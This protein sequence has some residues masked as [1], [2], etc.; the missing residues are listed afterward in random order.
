MTTLYK[1]KSYY[2]KLGVGAAPSSAP[3]ATVVDTDANTKLADA[4][5]TTALTNLV[6]YYE[7][8]YSGADNLD[9]V[10][11]FHTTD[12]T[13]DQ[14]DLV[15]YVVDKVYQGVAVASIANDAI[16]AA[17][18]KADAVTKI[19]NGL[20]LEATLTAIKGV[21]W[22]TETLAAIDVLIDAIKVKTDAFTTSSINYVSPISGS[23]ITIWRGDTL[24]VDIAN[25][26]SLASYVTLDFTI[27]RST[28][29]ADDDAIIR[30]R[31][32]ASGTGDGLLRL[33]G[34]AHST[35]TDG[36]ITITDAPTGD[37]TIMLKAGVTDDLVPG[38]YVY[39]VQLIGSAEVSTL[40]TGTLVVSA[41]VTR[42]VA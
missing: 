22:T 42:L 30:I 37:I 11:L 27:K 7:Y 31:K 33:N 2:T 19:Q 36:S 14:Q 4:Q 26:G 1:F 34:A 16:T 38:N 3:V 24:S 15:S 23:T 10:G 25:L 13:T 21:G 5:A 41:D 18:V 20:A 9:L 17:A 8:E 40:T 29:E 12:T 6:G 28:Y 32:N 39:D 35:G